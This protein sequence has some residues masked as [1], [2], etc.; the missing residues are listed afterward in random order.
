MEGGDS[1]APVGSIHRFLTLLARTTTPTRLLS[2]HFP[3]RWH[4]DTSL[5]DEKDTCMEYIY[6]V[7]PEL[8]NMLQKTCQLAESV[9]KY[10]RQELPEELSKTYKSLRHDLRIWRLDPEQFASTVPEDTMVEILRCQA[11]A[12]HNAVLIY[13]YRST[14]KSTPINLDYEVDTVLENLERAEDLKDG[15]LSGEKCTA[16]MSWPAFIAA[17][18]ATDRQP[19][20]D[21]WTRV[22]AY[23]MGNFDRQWKIVQELWDIV[24]GDESILDWKHALDKSDKI[25]L[26]I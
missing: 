5:F 15:Y 6:G 18:E 14:R 24:D 19:W 10:E 21:W 1:I 2:S 4:Q 13:F 25:V 8:G 9:S 20:R 23:N 22:Q 11:R 7:T 26:A 16:P 12:F 17:C 3:Q